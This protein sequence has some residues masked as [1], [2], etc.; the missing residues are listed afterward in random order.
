MAF[1]RWELARGVIAACLAFGLSAPVVAVI[2]LIAFDSG[3]ALF[4]LYLIAV[5]W[6]IGIVPA[7]TL[8][9]FAFAPLARLVGRRLRGE[10]RRWPHILSYASL[11]AVASITM[12]ALIG[13]LIGATSWSGDPLQGIAFALPVGA[14]AA[15]LAAAS[16]AYGWHFTARRAL[17]D[18]RATAAAAERNTGLA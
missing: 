11:G 9:G 7:T 13:L 10:P 3:Y 14:L 12:S 8:A 18:D 2:A 16:A 5:G 15:P 1:T 17:A 6:L 4:G